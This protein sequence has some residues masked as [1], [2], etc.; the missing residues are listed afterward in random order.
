MA[1]LFDRQALIRI[2][3]NNQIQKTFDQRFRIAFEIAKT[4]GQEANTL[5]VSIYN[6]S[7]SNR[8]ELVK[9]GQ[10]IEV[11]AGYSG[12]FEVVG[13]ANVN[14]VLIEHNPPNI[15]TT[16]EAADGVRTLRDVTLSL[17]FKGPVT[18]D[19]ILDEVAEK[20]GIGRVDTGA[21]VKG[22]YIHGFSFSGKA[23]EALNK[24]TAKANVIWSIQNNDL[25]IFDRFNSNLERVVL[26]TPQTGLIDSPQALEDDDAS[27]TRAKNRGY[28]VRSLL[29]PKIEVGNLLKLESQDVTGQFRIDSVV[30]T[31]DTRA[32]EWMT[33]AEI[34]A[35]A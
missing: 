5:K 18:V 11:E 12:N 13:I 34:H 29:N 15:I 21:D 9:S 19:R 7:R 22:Q 2:T 20:M 6:L 35:Q 1:D 32:N 27:E 4:I 3:Q 28:K 25:V 17:S 14:R 33:E 31:C 26:L 23:K 8:A 24:L 16:L 10:N 30:H